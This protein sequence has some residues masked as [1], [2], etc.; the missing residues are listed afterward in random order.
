MAVTGPGPLNVP[1]LG[2]YRGALEFRPDGAGGVQT[3][4]ALKLDNYVRGVISGEMPASW[5]AARPIFSRC[6]PRPRIR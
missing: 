2:A 6:R 1:G 3:V 5:S 4:D